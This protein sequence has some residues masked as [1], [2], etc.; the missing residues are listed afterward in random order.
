M[1][2]RMVS[3]GLRRRKSTTDNKCRTL[4]LV[5]TGEAGHVI[6]DLD[7]GVGVNIKGNVAVRP[8]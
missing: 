5:G 3:S 6:E 7:T 4:F 2:K 1:Q 8:K